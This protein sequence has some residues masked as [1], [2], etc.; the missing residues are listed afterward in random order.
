MRRLFVVIAISLFA[1]VGIV[2]AQST[3]LSGLNGNI[4]PSSISTL[5]DFQGYLNAGN[6]VDLALNPKYPQPNQNVTA[7]LTSYSYDLNGATIT[8]YINGKEV[9]AGK[10]IKSVTFTTG[11]LGTATTVKAIIAVGGSIQEK[12]ITVNPADITLLWQAN[13]YTPPFYKGKA[14]NSYQSVLTYVAVPQLYKNG[15]LVN[16]K[17]LVYTWSKN[18]TVLGDASG[19]GQQTFTLAGDVILR[20][21]IITV[22]V[23]DTAGTLSTKRSIEVSAGSPLALF[24][25]DSPTLGILFNKSLS[26]MKSLKL[27]E[28]NLTAI[29]F[30]F[31]ASIKQSS[32]LSFIWQMNG[33][34]MNI[35]DPNAVFRLPQDTSGQASV[36]VQVRNQTKFLQGADNSL[37]IAF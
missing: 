18:G 14:L 5:D 10:A 2:N 6:T 34:K 26:N 17:N 28:I 24:Y 30:F 3:D 31:S 12:T 8:W 4:D 7:T 27:P 32:A 15:Q 11:N 21:S 36:S 19:L 13:T 33:S 20:P 16:P 25:E 37:L 9:T 22:E 35:T 23:S 1:F 29:P